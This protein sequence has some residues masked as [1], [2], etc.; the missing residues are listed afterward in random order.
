MGDLKPIGSEKLQGEA[1]LKRIMEIARYNEVERTTSN[2]NETVDYTRQ[3]ADGKYYSIIHEKNGYIIKAGLN[4]SEMDYVERTEN[5]RYHTSYS[6]ALKKLNL[7]AKELNTLHE[8]EEGLNLFGEQEKKFVLKTPKPEVEEPVVEPVAE[9]EIDLDLGSDMG[10][11][12]G[13]EE[14]DLD[15]DLGMDDEGGEE[16]DMDMELDSEAPADD[17][18]VSIKTIQ[19][20][21]GKLGQKLRTIDSQDGLSSEDIKYVLNSIIS[22]VNLDN[23]TEE[24][25][26]DI[27]ANFEED[28]VDYGV[29][30]EA[31]LDVDAGDELDL[32]MDLEMD[33]EEPMEESAE[34][35]EKVMDEIFGESKIDKV[36]SKY[37]VVSDEEKTLTESKNIKKFLVE[38]IQKVTIRKEMKSM[39]ETVEQELTADF[40][41]K[42]NQSIKFLGKTNKGNLVFENEGQQIKV[43]QNGELL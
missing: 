19:K 41:L 26:E 6:K 30:D 10:S 22:A 36:L 12:D 17:E 27:L 32:D 39:C 31:E 13:G 3:L 1:K 8:N 28:E 9:P 20:L 14:L 21:T 5:R 43:S 42:E 7:L 25:K 15:M 34:V 35:G 16:V 37:F 4:E 11:E 23:L 29:D 24:D 33:V 18:E 40:L 38:K 2:V